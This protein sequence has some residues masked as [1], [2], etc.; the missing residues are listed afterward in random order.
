[1]GKILVFG[2]GYLGT[3]M[4]AA[5]EGSTLVDPGVCAD[6]CD[7]P[8][9]ERLL[10]AHRPDAVLNAA[11]RTGRPNI[12]WCES[13]RDAAFHSNVLGP[14]RLAEACSEAGVHLVHIGSG[15]VFFGESPRPGGWR[16]D[17]RANPDSYYTRTKYAADLLLEQ[18]PGVAIVRIRLPLDQIPG[19][20]NLI[21]KLA[22]YPTVA[23]ADNSVTVLEDLAPVVAGIVERRLT[24]VF[25]ATNPGTLRH[26][27]L[28][29]LYR[30]LVDGGHEY[31]LVTP[32]DLLARGVVK[33]A[34]S[35]CVLASPR[36]SEAGLDMPPIHES[37]PAI[38]RLYAEK[39]R[40][41]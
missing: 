15:C 4:A 12:D 22:G 34:R 3:R 36:L 25:H 2:R 6:I 39:L 14:Q 32:A 38:M 33:V 8:A 31:E 5:L 21:S 29:R 7:R 26:S 28:L 30:E 41:A 16:E 10:E 1:M 40:L 11:G 37:L 24:G 13:N 9:V 20:R 19:P 23:E 17:D 27:A 35:N 18:L